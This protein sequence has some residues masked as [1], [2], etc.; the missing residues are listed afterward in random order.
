MGDAAG[1]VE[2]AQQTA[3]ELLGLEF[4]E[5]LQAHEGDHLIKSGVIN[6]I[7]LTEM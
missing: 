3:G 2:A 6:V 1:D 4:H 5:L 7:R